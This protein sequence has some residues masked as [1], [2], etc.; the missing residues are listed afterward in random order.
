MFSKTKPLRLIQL[1]LI[2]FI[3]ISIVVSI[4]LFFYRKVAVTKDYQTFER[5]LLEDVSDVQ[6]EKMNY[7]KVETF[8]SKYSLDQLNYFEYSKPSKN[9]GSI[10]KLINLKDKSLNFDKD[11]IANS[12]PIVYSEFFETFNAKDVFESLESIILNYNLNYLILDSSL[13]SN[14]EDYYNLIERLNS[15][16]GLNL[17]VLLLPRTAELENYSVYKEFNKNYTKIVD[18]NR[19]VQYVDFYFIETYDYTPQKAALPG[20]NTKLSELED[21]IQYYIYKGIP[22]EKVYVGINKVSL[23]WSD[24][25]YEQDISKNILVETSQ[26]KV[27]TLDLT[28]LTSR[29]TNVDGE[30]IGY[31]IDDSTNKFVVISTT[32]KLVDNIKNIALKYSVKGVFFRF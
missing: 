26:A 23:S 11:Q 1:L 32:D 15:I 21:S 7:D 2:L 25:Y 22:R 24:R 20:P 10:A 14:L 5:I 3:L 8:D 27:F 28:E 12:I 16:Q 30:Q 13:Q 6:A 29:T 9:S 18:I 17:S 31:Y 4:Y 19:I